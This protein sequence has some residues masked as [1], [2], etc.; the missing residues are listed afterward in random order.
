M[1]VTRSRQGNPDWGAAA[2]R[3]CLRPDGRL[4][5]LDSVFWGGG[6]AGSGA[7]IQSMT[8]SGTR[9]A[10][11]H[12]TFPHDH[13]DGPLRIRTHDV[14][15][16]RTGV[17]DF[18]AVP[19][20]SNANASVAALAIDA[21]GSV[22]WIVTRRLGYESAPRVELEELYARG[23]GGRVVRLDAGIPG[24]LTALAFTEDGTLTWRHG[25]EPRSAAA[26][27]TT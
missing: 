22:A 5:S 24:A 6:G 7:S 13:S 21:D 8:V 2:Y 17:Q 9:L 26:A 14:A 20:H 1:L 19:G 15:R 12:Q 11:V 3:A 10:W 16:P 23:L 18:E 25:G 27:S 4:R